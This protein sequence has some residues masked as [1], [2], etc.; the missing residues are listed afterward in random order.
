MSLAQTFRHLSARPA[1]T[2][3]ILI[4]I[5]ASAIGAQFMRVSQA[6]LLSWCCA[7]AIYLAMAWLTASRAT[8][9]SM[10]R[11]AEQLDQGN[12]FIFAVTLGAALASVV[13][14]VFD[15][16]QARRDP[17]ELALGAATLVLSWFFVHTVFAFHYAHLYY[18]EPKSLQ[19]PGTKEPCYGE[20]MYFALVVGMTAQVSDVATGTAEMRRVVMTHGVIAFFFNTAILALGVNLAAGLAH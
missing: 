16:G 8:V 3:S 6:V 19:F 17:T 9:A 7:A 2:A 10:R 20:F 11:R 12:G 4:A 5:G 15:L 18:N 14:I 13:A 1:L